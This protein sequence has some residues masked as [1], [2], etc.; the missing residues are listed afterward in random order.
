MEVAILNRLELKTE[1]VL[2]FVLLSFSY[3]SW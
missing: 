3:Y 2:Y 1:I